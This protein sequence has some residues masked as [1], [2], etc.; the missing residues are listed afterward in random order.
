[1][2]NT[3]GILSPMGPKVALLFFEKMISFCEKLYGAKSEGDFPN[4]VL[5]SLSQESFLGVHTDEEKFKNDLKR[6]LENFK[7]SKIDFLVVP[8]N[9]AHVYY[10][11]ITSF[12]DVPVLHIAKETI[13]LIPK[14][15]TKPVLLGTS[16]NMGLQIYQNELKKNKIEYFHDETIQN[17]V[18]ELIISVKQTGVSSHTKKLWQE[19]MNYCLE[20]DCDSIISTCKN[21]NCCL[22]S[23]NGEIPVTDSTESLALACVKKYLSL[24]SQQKQKK[25]NDYIEA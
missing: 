3:I 7:Q 4:V 14:N 13:N 2:Q 20:N 8:S 15:I 16:L 23:H 24:I 9:Y 19:L 6:G 5:Y 10:D 1:M 11:Y 21:L 17:Y 12:V 25:Y 22:K 18:S